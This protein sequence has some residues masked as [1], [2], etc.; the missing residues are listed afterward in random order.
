MTS[1]ESVDVKEW[2]ALVGE[3]KQLM[4]AHDLTMENAGLKIGPMLTVDP[5]TEQ[6]VGSDSE[7]ANK[8][9]KREYR[10]PFV[11]PEVV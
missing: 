3:M 10:A 7:Q 2:K 1:A 8:L 9:L 4:S 11:V 6:F 5:K